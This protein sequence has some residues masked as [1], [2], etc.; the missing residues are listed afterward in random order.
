MFA[1]QRGERVI[2]STNTLNL[3]D[4]LFFKDIPALQRIMAA[5]STLPIN[6]KRKTAADPPF[7]AA[8]L[9]GRGNYLCIRRY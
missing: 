3:Q 1:A 5:D 2:I 8:L 7:T 6:K 4:Q 9:K